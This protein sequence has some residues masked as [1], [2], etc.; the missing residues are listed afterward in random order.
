MYGITLV[1]AA[2]LGVPFGVVAYRRRSSSTA[3]RIFLSRFALVFAGF[4]LSIAI[5]GDHLTPERRESGLGWPGQVLSL[6]IVTAN[7][8]SGILELRRI[9]REKP[10]ADIVKTFD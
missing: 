8:I 6:L 3:A 7:M 4:V 2:V 5:I 10:E 9:N 1:V